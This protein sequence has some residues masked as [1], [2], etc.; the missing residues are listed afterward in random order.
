[1]SC[2][3]GILSVVFL[4][5]PFISAAEEYRF[6]VLAPLSGDFASYGGQVQEGIE[7]A[8]TELRDEG[9][10][11]DFIYMDAC[12]SKDAIT[13]MEALTSVQHVDGIAANF[14]LA[15]VPGAAPLAQ[16][17]KLPFIHTAA[18]T[19][20]V[21]TSG[22]YIFATNIR[23]RDEAYALAEHAWNNLHAK[24]A[25]VLFVTTDFGA[26][27]D[28][29]FT[30]RFEALGGH[31]VE[32]LTTAPGVNDFRGEILRVKRANPDVVLLAH[33]GKTLGVLLRQLKIAG[34][35]AARLGTY[36]TEDGGVIETAGNAAEGI[37]YFVPVRAANSAWNSFR[38]S[39]T[40]ARN[41]FDGAVILG[42]AV[43]E[44]RGNRECAQRRLESV[45]DYRGASGVFS[46]NP[47]GPGGRKM[48]LRALALQAQ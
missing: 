36:E 20:L 26:D 5:A 33:L 22:E 18:A 46:L 8:R 27:Y 4:M 3:K 23:V 40:I 48:E 35:K 30:E 43:H 7:A 39:S 38:L 19:E 41:A 11:A 25:A 44:C 2:I 15:A 6:G 37:E 10:R 29:F 12:F 28:R 21:L 31:V 34:V 13:A 47:S 1:M 16:R 45:K 24:T 9:I 42:R 32:H 14:C 17:E